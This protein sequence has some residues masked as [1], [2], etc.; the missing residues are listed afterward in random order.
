MADEGNVATLVNSDGS[1]GEGWLDTKTTDEKGND[2]NL[3]DDDT[4][5]DQLTKSFK[6]L[7]DLVKNYRSAQKLVGR[8]KIIV[9]GDDA[10]DEEWDNVFKTLGMPD[11]AEDY[12]LTYD[13][14]M[15]KEL[16]SKENLDWY[17]QEARKYRLLPWQAAGIFKD[18]NDL[19][20]GAHKKTLDD[21]NV[22]LETG[23]MQLKDKLGT[24]FNEKMDACDAIIGAVTEA[25]EEGNDLRQR[26]ENDVRRDPRVAK[27]FIKLGEMI[28]EDR[29]GLIQKQNAFGLK[30][31]EASA[32]IEEIKADPA[33]L[34]ENSP[35]HKGLVE[36]MT[37]LHR[38]LYPV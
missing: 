36:R 29:M 20:S 24:T 7:P 38:I 11:K 16:Q 33:Y 26:L 3:F 25:G 17:H 31:S 12:K 35:K 27:V 1:F 15:P 37:T 21:F 28:S 30:P 23:M 2:V 18:W 13:E 34:D 5:A 8:N 10:P 4:R 19:Q 32:Q 9:P 14:K 22:S 6:G